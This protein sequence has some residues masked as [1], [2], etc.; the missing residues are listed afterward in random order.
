MGAAPDHPLASPVHNPRGATLCCRQGT[1]G[2]FERESSTVFFEVQTQVS[3]PVPA[4]PCLHT[5]PGSSEC[6]INH[7][8]VEPAGLLYQASDCAKNSIVTRLRLIEQTESYPTILCPPSQLLKPDPTL[9][10]IV[11]HPPSRS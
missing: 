1:F 3:L 11:P 2:L 7:I 8:S 5:S 9:P 4:R 10:G 6:L